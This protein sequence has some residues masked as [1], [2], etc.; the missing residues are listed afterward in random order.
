LTKTSE[1]DSGLVGAYIFRFKAIAGA[2][3]TGWSDEIA[4]NKI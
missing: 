2:H 3:T 1:A 4:N